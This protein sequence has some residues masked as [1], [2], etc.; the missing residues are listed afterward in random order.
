[1]NARQNGFSDPSCAKSVRMA[2]TCIP[3]TLTL[4]RAEEESLCAG[5]PILEFRVMYGPVE[6][7]SLSV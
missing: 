6:S 7:T 2:G 5:S 1:M 3:P 4:P